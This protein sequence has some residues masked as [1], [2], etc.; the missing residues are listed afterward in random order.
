MEEQNK[1]KSKIALIIIAIIMIVAL[2]IIGTI[3]TVNIQRE[4]EQK[5]TAELEEQN[6]R[7]VPN[8]VGITRKE[9]IEELKK[10]GLEYVVTPYT[11]I[12][13]D[14]IVTSQSPEAGKEVKKG[15][16]VTIYFK[17]NTTNDKSNDKFYLE[18]VKLG[19]FAPETVKGSPSTSYI[20]A[21]ACENI[22]KYWPNAQI[23]SITIKESDGYGRFWII[24]K[25][26]KS[27]TDRTYS[28]SH[29]VIEITVDTSKKYNV[30]NAR[31]YLDEGTG[32]TGVKNKSNW[33]TPIN[34]N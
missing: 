4:K 24:S 19:E 5:E 2:L 1:K 13:D 15:D 14:A 34:N 10:N 33:G 6:K 23:N 16:S 29:D 3:V 11:V 32:I 12:S 18:D 28:Y 26:L 25:F 21:L 8:L 7:N 22:L 20:V 27:G 9:A 17:A 30:G 31:I